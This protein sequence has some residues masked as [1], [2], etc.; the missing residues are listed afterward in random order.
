MIMNIKRIK[1]DLI[2]ENSIKKLENLCAEWEFWSFPQT[3][4]CLS[5]PE[6]EL[7]VLSSDLENGRS[8]WKGALLSNHGPFSADIIYLYIKSEYRGKGFAQLLLA[9]LWATLGKTATMES[10]FLEVR[11]SNSSAIKTYRKFGMEQIGLRK[12]YYQ[13]GED[14]LV[15]SKEKKIES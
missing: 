4:E 9:S 11:S 13:D 5:R 6:Y 15:F 1:E 10:L 7:Y 14:A 12:S 2:T 8:N 3:L